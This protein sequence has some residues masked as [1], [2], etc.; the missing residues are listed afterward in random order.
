MRSHWGPIAGL[1]DGADGDCFRTG[2]GPWEIRDMRLFSYKMTHDSGFAPNPFGHTLTLAT[3]KPQIRLHKSV[4]DW[5][6]GFTSRTLA[7][8]EVGAERLVY[9]MRV[10][11]KLPMRDYFSDPRFQDKVPDMSARGP[12]AKAGDNIYCPLRPNADSWADFEQLPNLNHWNRDRP[13]EFHHR[14]D[15]SGQYVLIADEFYYFGGNALDL[16]LEC[17]PEVPRGQ[18]GHGKNTPSKQARC[19][20]DYICSRFQPGRHGDPHRWPKVSDDEGGRCG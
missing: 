7:G 13:N 6:A 15:V 1:L 16:P 9:L 14:R 3:C 12:M 8:H 17:R 10:A 2:R 11:E 18:S 20:V 19:F 4:N 5:I